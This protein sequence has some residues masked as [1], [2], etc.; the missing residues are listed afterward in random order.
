MMGKILALAIAVTFGMM[1]AGCS[2]KKESDDLAKAQECLDKLKQ[3]EIAEPGVNLDIDFAF[4]Y[5]GFKDF[6]KA[7]HFLN[8]TYEE[9]MGIACMGMIF[10]VRY[11]M[12]NELKSDMRFVQLLEKMGLEKV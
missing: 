1:A 12:L 4:I 5:S 2:K 9:R 10:C 6:D 7:F 11:P 8:K 3:R